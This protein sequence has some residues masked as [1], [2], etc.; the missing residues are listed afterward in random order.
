MSDSYIMSDTLKLAATRSL[1]PKDFQRKT[2]LDELHRPDEERF[3]EK[4]VGTMKTGNL[5][6][7]HVHCQ[8]N[9]YERY[10]CI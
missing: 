3:L 7:I 6:H 10:L 2:H 1:R 9:P 4:A 8:L 5:K